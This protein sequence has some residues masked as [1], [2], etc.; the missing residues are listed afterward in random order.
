MLKKNFQNK[1]YLSNIIEILT[2]GF[3]LFL[4]LRLFIFI[5]VFILNEI[6]GL[7]GT[8]LLSLNL[9]YNKEIKKLDFII[10]IFLSV[11]MIIDILFIKNSSVYELLWIFCYY[12]V[13]LSIENELLTSKN[14]LNFSYIYFLIIIVLSFLNKDPNEIFNGFSRNGISAMGIFLLSL[15]YLTALIKSDYIH[16]YPV[17]LL[18]YVCLWSTG[19]SA[20]FISIF[21]VI[22]LMFINPSE[23]K[24]EIDKKFIISCLLFL[25]L[26]Y[27]ITIIINMIYTPN[28]IEISPAIKITAI[29]NTSPNNVVNPTNVISINRVTEFESI[30]HLERYKLNSPRF[31]FWYNYIVYI[32]SNPKALLFG[33]SR[34]K[35]PQLYPYGENLHSFLFMLHSK[36]GLIGFIPVVYLLIRSFFKLLK[37]T[38]ITHLFVFCIFGS[39]A[40]LDWLG[41]FGYYDILFYY[42]MFTFNKDLF[43]DKSLMIFSKKGKE[44]NI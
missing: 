26:Y 27:F 33:A 29:N 39:R 36:T 10:I 19:R 34:L 37:S 30:K 35:N 4:F 15:Y 3:I 42:I 22:L 7:W 11:G 21:W 13:Y 25:I 16:K 32:I 28:I 31:K 18:L 44:I 5:N 40:L 2:Y 24:F 41:F 8:F 38:K 1:Y 20:L 14:I 6:L 23:N 9:I 17:F 43:S 12:G